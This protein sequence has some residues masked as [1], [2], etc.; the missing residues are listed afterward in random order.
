MAKVEMLGKR[1]RPVTGECARLFY[2]REMNGTTPDLDE[3][4]RTKERF[5]RIN[6]RE[7]AEHWEAEREEMQN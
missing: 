2:N 1:K 3:M 6:F 5:G 4:R 7:I